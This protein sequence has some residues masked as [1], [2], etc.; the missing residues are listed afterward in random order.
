MILV[1]KNIKEL[2][3]YGE[4]IVLNYKEENVKSISYDLTIGS[5]IKPKENDDET[6]EEVDSYTLNP[7]DFIFIKTSEKLKI[8]TNIL[9]RIA[10]KNSL[11]R[12]G[13]VVSGPHYQPGHTTYAFLKVCN[14]SYNKITINKE[15]KIA[16]IIF[17]EL[18][19]IP[20]T[21]YNI[22]SSSSFNNEDTYK[23]Y[24]NYK[25]K[26]NS[27]IEKIQKIQSDIEKKEGSI[28]SNILT[29]MGIFV[30]VFSLITINFEAV[31]K[32]NLE[33][34]KLIVL[35]LSLG[36][37]ITFFMGL[38]LIFIK[39]K[40]NKHFLWWFLVL[41]L[42]LVTINIVAITTLDGS[43]IDQSNKEV[44]VTTIMEQSPE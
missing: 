11:I 44:D 22:D 36:L 43:R 42:I 19:E 7:G 13:L 32:M 4:L 12:T 16:Q 10:E 26:Y 29:F 38:I 28:Y 37:V 39:K 8:P 25:N 40:D 24:G 23:G 15:D 31:A 18:K 41:L 34:E 3:N 9:G 30:S 6:T 17:E 5:I 35:D 2:V 33:F 20:E 1:D 14:T 27:K 21:P